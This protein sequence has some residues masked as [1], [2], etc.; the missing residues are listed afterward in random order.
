LA[1]SGT[2]LTSSFEHPP[3]LS[4]CGRPREIAIEALVPRE[5][6]DA[7]VDA[8]PEYIRHVLRLKGNA[9]RFGHTLTWTSRSVDRKVD[10]TI[11]A[12]GGKTIIRA[13]EHL[14]TLAGGLYGGIVGGVGGGGLGAALA[15]GVAAMHSGI[16]TVGLVTAFLT[17]SYGLARTIYVG[18][19]ESRERELKRLV[20][21]IAEQLGG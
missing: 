6:P 18:A 19:A 13:D 16:I 14:G 4:W 1:T 21:R 10:I 9:S 20:Q 17:G 8:V 3:H 5:A 2:A 11:T 7:E 15:I 12:R